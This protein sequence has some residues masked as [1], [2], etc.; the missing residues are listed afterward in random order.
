MSW[1]EQLQISRKYHIFLNA[2]STIAIGLKEWIRIMIF[3][4][5]R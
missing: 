3:H 1:G 4:T 2:V 5:V